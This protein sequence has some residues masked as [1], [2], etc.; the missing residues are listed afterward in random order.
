MIAY[1][2]RKLISVLFFCCS[3]MHALPSSP[4]QSIEQLTLCA[5]KTMLKNSSLKREK[6]TIC[7]NQYQFD[8]HQQQ[9]QHKKRK[10]KLNGHS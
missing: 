9:P 6:K 5:V 3:D 8:T 4:N 7:N 2:F 1:V 10:K